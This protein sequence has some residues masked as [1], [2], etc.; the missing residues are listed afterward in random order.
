MK[1]R[2]H[3]LL[4]KWQPVIGKQVD[5]WGVKKMKT[6]WGGCNTEKRRIWLNL[7]LAKK[8]PQCLE[9]ILVHELVHLHERH[10]NEHFKRLM[11]KFLPSWRSSREALKRDPLGHEDW[12]Y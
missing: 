11:D 6:K 1:C 2:I 3:E 5:H 8:L 4:N 9:Y 10:H 7:E 12:I